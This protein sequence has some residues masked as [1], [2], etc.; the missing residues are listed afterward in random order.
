MAQSSQVAHAPL[1]PPYLLVDRAALLSLST[2]GPSWANVVTWSEKNEPYAPADNDSNHD[3]IA[4]A[5]ALRGARENKVAF[6]NKARNYLLVAALSGSAF[7]DPTINSLAIGRNTLSYVLAADLID[8]ENQTAVDQVFRAWLRQLR[9]FVWADGR[10]LK[11]AHEGRPNNWGLMCGASRIAIDMYLSDVRSLEDLKQA[12]RVFHGW[13]GAGSQWSGFAF[14]G[15]APQD[16]S[17]QPNNDPAQYRGIAPPGATLGGGAHDADGLLPDDQRRVGDVE[18]LDLP[19]S[20]PSGWGA[21]TSYV[22]EALQGAVMQ[23]HLLARCGYEAFSWE[24]NALE[25]AMTWLYDRYGFPP[26]DVPLACSGGN[27]SSATW[28]PHITDHYYGTARAVTLGGRPGK[29][30]GFADWWIQ[31]LD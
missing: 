22:W 19:L 28:V 16:N 17:W 9:A 4:L 14:G 2:S 18:C 20:Y 26:E 21:R 8:L 23:A 11:S 3:V 1:V 15:G 10:T 25:R 30:C 31:A 29:N 6:R 12:K 5:A 13:L 27:V 7:A 24:S